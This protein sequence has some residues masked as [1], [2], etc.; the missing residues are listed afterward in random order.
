MYF[1]PFDVFSYT[2]QTHPENNFFRAT[3]FRLHYIVLCDDKNS[4]SM[5]GNPEE[6]LRL[7]YNTQYRLCDDVLWDGK[8]RADGSAVFNVNRI[9]Q[10]L[11]PATQ[12]IMTQWKDS[13]AGFTHYS[14]A[15]K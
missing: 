7:R 2:F 5:K 12:D 11:L 14:K 6:L 4:S 13:G 8:V 15:N 9:F 3:E 10:H 1:V